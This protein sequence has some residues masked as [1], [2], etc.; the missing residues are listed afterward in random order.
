MNNTILIILS[1]ARLPSIL[2]N[3][4]K[5]IQTVQNA[6][7]VWESFDHYF[8]CKQINKIFLAGN[9]KQSTILF[10]KKQHD[11]TLLGVRQICV[12]Y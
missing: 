6:I 2:V 10:V 7:V 12:N 3:Q 11:L 1:W 9:K 8:L 4:N 5:T